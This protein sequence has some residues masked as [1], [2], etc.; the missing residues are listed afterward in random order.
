MSRKVSEAL[1]ALCQREGA[2]PFMALLAAFQVL[3]SRYSGQDDISVGSPIA[4]RNRA[5]TE[6]LIGFF[7]NTLVLRSHL[8][9]GTSFR[10]LLAQVRATT[11]AAY[12]HQD[13]PFE[14]LVEVL[15]P[16]RDLSRSPLFQ[17]MFILQNT[18]GGELQLP[19]LTLRPVEHEDTTAK[20]EL[21][22]A[23]GE[24]P[25]GF[26]GGL[27]YNTD[28]FDEATAARMMRH[29]EALLEVLSARP[30][31]ALRDLPLLGRDEERLLL[32]TWNPPGELPRDGSL[33]HTRLE[34]QAR[35]T[36]DALAVADGTRSLTHDELMRRS[37]RLA[38]HLRSLGVGPEVRVGVCLRRTVELPVALLA[39]LKAGGTYAP[40]DPDY[41]SER[42]G[43]L[44]EDSC[45]ALVISERSVL[46]ALPQ[47]RPQTLVLEELDAVLAA[48][49]D[50]PL[51]TSCDAENLAYLIYTSGST[52]RPKG[53]AITHR[54]AALFITW[55]LK[56]FAP[57]ELQGVLAATSVCFD[58]S[59]FELF[60]P[61]SCGGRVLLVPNALHLPAFS[62]R[63]EVTLVN[64]V[65]SAMAELVRSGGLPRSVRTVNL[66]GEALPRR[67]V[68]A[69][70]ALGHVERVLNLYGPSEDTTYS[71]F[72]QV[73]RDERRSPAIGRPLENTQAYVLDRHLRLVPPGVPG[74]LYLAGDGLARGYLLR[75]DLT[76]ERFLPD[77]YSR[78]PGGRMYKTGD[79]VRYLPDGRLDYLG[80]LDHQVKL[81]GF[82]IELGEIE[83]GPRAPRL[84]APGPWPSCARTC[85]ATSA[86]WPTSPATR[87]TPPSCAP[88]SCG[89]CPSTWC[90][91]P[92]WPWRRCP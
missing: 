26:G 27:S 35:R 51:P 1:K 92:S 41:P 60:V 44:L 4:G 61:L 32:E 76:A 45:S 58:L 82:R 18:P 59:I 84:G 36:P 89:T 20:F 86:W 11:L 16:T 72:E 68:D 70:Y 53:V 47:E 15:Q 31:T 40:L 29:F 79:L 75:P 17:V 28:L 52:G 12:A 8:S 25:E 87:P 65:P 21:T 30:D 3:L 91:R 63:D 39:V 69:L 24:G 22:L 10:E 42:L 50:E 7:V 23:L 85:P 33:L 14:K 54:S 34:A 2:T 77:P 46:P 64:T 73:P 90:P 78:T 57:S 88:T 55:A 80:R 83:A 67:T 62:R 38:R 71:T 5:E 56:V 74:E 48:Q 19:G 43:Y 37:N 81:R 9:E 13:V 49:S 6:G 66:A